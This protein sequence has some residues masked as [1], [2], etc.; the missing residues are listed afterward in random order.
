LPP[1]VTT[2]RQPASTRHRRILAID[3]DAGLLDMLQLL[4]GQSNMEFR[5]AHGGQAGFELATTWEPDLI[6]LDL[7]MPDLDGEAFLERYREAAAAPASVILLTGAHDGRARAAELGVTRYLAK[8]FDLAVL[9][10]IVDACP[11]R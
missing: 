8:P 4:L 5:T 6:L 3:D 1:S 7:S 11:I 10:D 2:L 9:V